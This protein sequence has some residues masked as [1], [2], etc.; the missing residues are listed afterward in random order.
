[1]TYKNSIKIL[2]SNFNIAWKTMI[3]Y[4]LCFFLC[5]G[6]IVWC[7]SPIYQILNNAGFLKIIVD[8]YTDF[9]ES[10]DLNQ[11]F[12]TI[13]HLINR[14]V[15]IMFE[16]LSQFWLSFILVVLIILI[17]CSIISNLTIMPTCNTLNY[18]M[19]SMNKHGFFA[20]VGETFGKNIKAQLSYFLVSL[21]INCI[22][23]LLLILGIRLV[24][25]TWILSIFA[26]FILFLEVVLIYAFKVSLFSSWVP[27]MVVL[28]HG[29]FKSLRVSIKN[30]FRNF[31]KVY[32]SAIGV[33]ITI[34]VLNLFLALFTCFAGL[35]VSIPASF[36]LYSSFGMVVT[37][38][39]QGMRYYVDVCNVVT[40]KK[41]EVTDKLSN[42][43]YIV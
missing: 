33:V 13:N 35:L 21:P 26:G 17:F 25:A 27:T 34:I 22:N 42:M 3:Y 15:E 23:I 40:P 8:L 5:I 32:S 19:G 16:N 14:F 10:F 7:L 4:F 12:E 39:S 37:Y 1:M 24:S 31:K 28:N 9:F 36:L 11:L 38:E 18:Y 41:R 30:M 6:L 43:K 20:S 2:F 29:V